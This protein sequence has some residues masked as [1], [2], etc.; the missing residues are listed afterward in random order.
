MSE[1]IEK[2]TVIDHLDGKGHDQRLAE[3]AALPV[4]SGGGDQ[5]NRIPDSASIRNG[6]ELATWRLI[7]I[8]GMMAMAFMNIVST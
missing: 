4:L 5:V 3:V 7:L 1:Q 8:C 6:S 2:E